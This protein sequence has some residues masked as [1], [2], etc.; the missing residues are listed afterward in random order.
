MVTKEFSKL[1]V[2]K[3]DEGGLY[4]DLHPEII[5]ELGWVTGDTLYW[6][7]LGDGRWSVSNKSTQKFN[8]VCT[9][10]T[11]GECVHLNC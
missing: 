10:C 8:P 5:K 3:E 7:N 9:I 1:V 6:E 11:P 2:V 4:F